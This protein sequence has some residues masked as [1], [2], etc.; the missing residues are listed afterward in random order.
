[1]IVPTPQVMPSA[2][3]LIETLV[4]FVIK[5]AE[6]EVFRPEDRLSGRKTSF[7]AFLMTNNT[8]VS[9]K[10][11]ALGMTW[12]IGTIILLFYNGVALGAICEDYIADGQTKFLVGWLLPHGSFEMPAILIAGQAGLILGG[13]LIGWGKRTSVKARLRQI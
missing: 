1:M 2:S 10:T 8:S 7:S 5:N 3:V 6:N 4:L 11:L 12:G 9:I 13:A